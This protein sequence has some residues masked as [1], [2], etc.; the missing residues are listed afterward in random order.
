MR[1][2]RVAS[3]LPRCNYG[4]ISCLVKTMNAYIQMFKGGEQALNLVRFDPLLLNEV[5]IIQG[6]QSPVSINLKF[7]NASIYGL[8][9]FRVTNVV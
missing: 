9:E 1:S 8:D 4:D 2:L 5:N 6:T 7:M 3:Q